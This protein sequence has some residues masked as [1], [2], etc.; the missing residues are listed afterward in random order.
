MNIE[1]KQIDETSNLDRIGFHVDYQRHVDE[2]FIENIY[3]TSS[4][5]GKNL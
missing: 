2:I 5:A 1:R 4:C 3:V